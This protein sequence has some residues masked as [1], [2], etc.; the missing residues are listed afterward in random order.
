MKIEL[1]KQEISHIILSC[2]ALMEQL[3]DDPS[4]HLAKERW[5]KLADI[6]LKLKTTHE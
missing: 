4:F 2:E 5:Y 3:K 1:N 6:I